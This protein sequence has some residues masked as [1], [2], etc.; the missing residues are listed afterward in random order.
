MIKAIQTEYNGYK[1]RSRLEARWAVF[2][3][4]IGIKYQYE[5]EGFEMEDGTRYLPDFYLPDSDRWIEIKGKPL[6]EKELKK[7]ESFCE[8]EY[9]WKKKF[10]IF[11][12]NP[13][14]SIV[15][16]KGE[17]VLVKNINSDSISVFEVGEK[18]EK[19]CEWGIK[20]YSWVPLSDIF[21]DFVTFWA[22]G[23]AEKENTLSRFVPSIWRDASIP[24]ER[25]AAA[26]K[27]A[28]Q[29]RFEHGEKP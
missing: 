5:P 29:A 22:D 26:V 4:T 20:A 25:F 6:S 12:G 16:T 24:L 7:C 15:S 17:S 8:G 10:V 11:V 28:R 1:F 21:P 27:K 9:N 23:L 14:I 2:F 3:D 18:D 19:Y 13:E